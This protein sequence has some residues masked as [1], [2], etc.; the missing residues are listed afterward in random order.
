M[1]KKSVSR[2]RKVIPLHAG[3]V[4]PTVLQLTYDIRFDLVSREI[5]YLDLDDNILQVVV[6]P[7]NVIVNDI[8]WTLEKDS[9]GQPDYE[10][11]W[12]YII[13]PF[14]DVLRT[15]QPTLW[16]AG[17]NYRDPMGLFESLDQAS[18]FLAR[19]AAMKP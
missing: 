7:P 10:N 1:R 15:Q 2:K 13:F 8:E 19:V 14:G 11:E 5:R 6:L 17:L 9:E 12:S 3:K 4:E 18:A 16:E